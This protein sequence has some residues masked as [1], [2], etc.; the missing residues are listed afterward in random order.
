MPLP[1]AA[2]PQG[3]A[4]GAFFNKCVKL[5]GSRAHPQLINLH[6]DRR[7]HGTRNGHL[8]HLEHHVARML[9]HLGADLDQLLAQRGQGPVLDLAGQR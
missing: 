7:E 9:D 1:S 6:Q 8:S 5:T 4:G 3:L 2:L